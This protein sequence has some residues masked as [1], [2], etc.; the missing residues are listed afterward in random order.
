[1]HKA[2]PVLHKEAKITQQALPKK[3]SIQF[4]IFVLI[5]F[6]LFI[7]FV[8]FIPF[9]PFILFILFTLFTLFILLILF[10]SLECS[11]FSPT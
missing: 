3:L 10:Y 7:L 4:S 2:V 11:R 1:M 6:V 8:L 9:I 5:P